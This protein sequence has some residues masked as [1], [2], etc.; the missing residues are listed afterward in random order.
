M[1][2]ETPRIRPVILSGGS[3]TRLWPLSRDQRPK[4]LQPLLSER[5]MLQETLVRAQDPSSDAVFAKPLIVANAAY[6]DEIS[7]QADEVLEGGAALLLEPLGRNTAPAALAAAFLSLREHARQD[8]VLLVLPADHYIA[9][10]DAFRRTVT[11]AAEAA[12]GGGL[13]TFGIRPIAPETGYG[14]IQRG[15]PVGPLFRVKSFK[16]KPSL[17]TARDFLADGGYYW[18]AGM[19]AF[20]IDALMDAA[21]A[22]CSGI[23]EAVEE[24]VASGSWATAGFSL[25]TDAFTRCPSDSIDYAIME[26]SDEVLTIPSDF[27]W[28]DIGSW[29]AL[30]ELSEADSDGNVLVGDVIALDSRDSYVRTDHGLAAVVG[31]EDL[32]LVRSGDSV[33]VA[34]KARAQDVKRLVEELKKRGLRKTARPQPA[35]A[36][37]APRREAS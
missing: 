31:I 21:R 25:G 4:Q 22:H 3:G 6:A 2:G 13:V 10:V 32:I 12:S 14:Y 20:R 34:P 24:A 17:E 16:E 33:M 7:R 1:A 27:G 26:K 11:A 18:N 5:S 36:S 30:A 15:D 19:F 9:D 29:T 23:L 35:N 8:E 37:G 28:S